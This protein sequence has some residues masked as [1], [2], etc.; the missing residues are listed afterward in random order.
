M[1]SLGEPVGLTVL[2]LHFFKD[3]LPQ[4]SG[5]SSSSPEQGQWQSNEINCENTRLIPTGDPKVRL[6][7][8]GRLALANN[9]NNIEQTHNTL[10]MKGEKNL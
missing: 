10:N 4:P 1:A 9:A 5:E 7:T 8:I 3:S 6:A 2:P